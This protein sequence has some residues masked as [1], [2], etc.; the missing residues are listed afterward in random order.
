ML[1]IKNDLVKNCERNILKRI[2]HEGRNPLF[3]GKEGS[4]GFGKVCM[5]MAQSL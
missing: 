2:K 4:V 1:V 3:D 5:E